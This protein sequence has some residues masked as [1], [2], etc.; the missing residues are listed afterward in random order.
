MK[1][2]YKNPETRIFNVCLHPLMT[3]ST[4]GSGNVKSVGVGGNYS[5]GADGVL[6]RD[7]QVWDDE[8]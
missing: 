8:D 7:G 5:G 2:T 6:S 1:K 4:D 3:L